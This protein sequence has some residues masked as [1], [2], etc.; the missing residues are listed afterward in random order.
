MATKTDLRT[1]LREIRQHAGPLVAPSPLDPAMVR[2]GMRAAFRARKRPSWLTVNCGGPGSGRPGPCP[3]PDGENGAIRRGWTMEEAKSLVA[4]LPVGIKIVGGVRERGSSA[5]DLD[6]YAGIRDESSIQHI[7]ER[8]ESLGY[9]FSSH[10]E[11]TPS[12]ARE[13]IAAGKKHPRGH[14]DV[15]GFDHADGRQID[16]WVSRPKKTQTNNGKIVKTIPWKRKEARR[17]K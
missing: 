11:V 13:A 7:T 12:M 9:G 6:L 17:G 3:E 5:N 14:S 16:L 2:R 4:K 1:V 10:T 8:L 15:F